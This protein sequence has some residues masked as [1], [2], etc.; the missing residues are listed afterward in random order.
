MK[1]RHAW[2]WVLAVVAVICWLATVVALVGVSAES[3]MSEGHPTPW[4]VLSVVIP[5]AMAVLLTW[6]AFVLGSRA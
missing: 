3:A 2:S 1:K 6:R 4:S 5:A